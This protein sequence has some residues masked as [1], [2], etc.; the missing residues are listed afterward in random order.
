LRFISLYVFISIFVFE[1]FLVSV[2]EGVLVAQDY[3]TETGALVDAAQDGT[4][5]VFFGLDEP[6][7]YAQ[8]IETSE[9]SA[10]LVT[11]ANTTLNT[12]PIWWVLRYRLY[13]CRP[14]RAHHHARREG[15]AG[16]FCLH[17]Q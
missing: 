14:R 8:S 4:K 12:G 6:H 17:C 13:G 9:G 3:G 1:S 5:K 10:L 2:L 16:R 7:Y 11:S 15:E